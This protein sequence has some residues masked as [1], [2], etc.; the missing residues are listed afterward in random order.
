MLFQG[1]R[2][3][4]STKDGAQYDTIGA[5]WE[6]MSAKYG[7]E[8][9][10]GLGCS[11]TEDTIEYVIGL[12]NGIIGDA[13]FTAELPDTGWITVRGRTEELGRMYDEIYRDGRLLYEIETFYENGECEVQYVR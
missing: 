9:L 12:K 6:E 5:F 13:D 2:R 4:F 7:I 3:V 8:N 1:I 11:W 10:R